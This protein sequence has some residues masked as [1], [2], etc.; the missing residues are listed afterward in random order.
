[1]NLLLERM[2]V[3]PNELFGLKVEVLRSRRK[4]SALHIVGNELQ[5]RV[6]KSIGDRN[7]V[8]ILEIKERWIRNKAIQ[9]QNQPI[10]KKKRIY[11]RR[12]FLSF[13]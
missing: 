4:T 10:L 12:I 8:K 11:K 2:S 6:P 13:W 7:I 9:L 5:I 3:I 1:M